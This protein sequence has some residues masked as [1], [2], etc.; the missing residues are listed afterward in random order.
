MFG[1][2]KK[3]LVPLTKSF[4]GFEILDETI[5]AGHSLGSQSQAHSYGRDQTF[6]H[7][8]HDDTWKILWFSKWSFF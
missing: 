5:L 8:R 2:S 3:C 6:R 4:D 1:F 7:V